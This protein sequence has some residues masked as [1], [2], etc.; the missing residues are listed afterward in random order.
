MLTEAPTGAGVEAAQRPRSWAARIPADLWILAG[1]TVLA[2]VLRFATLTTQSYWFDE[3]QAAH[4][5][6]LGFGAMLSTWNAN[7]PNPPLFFVLAWPWAHIFG[8]GEAGLRS[9]SAI[10]GVAVIPI[11]WLCG[12][13]LV[14]SRAGLVAAAL[15]AVNPFLIWYSQEAR[16]YMLLTALTG[17]S[18]WLL[19]RAWRAPTAGRL[20]WWA[21]VAALA[22]STQYFA[23]FL[24]GPEA[25]VLLYMLRNRASVVAV[26]PPVAAGL[27]FLPHALDHA[28]HPAG[29]INSVGP[30]AVRLKQV[31]VAFGLNTLYRSSIV[32]YGL[33]G[34]ALLVGVLIVL[35][36]AGAEGRQLRGAGIAAGLAACALLIPLTLALA[37]HDY[38]EA[39]ALIPAW[40]PL[41]VVIGAAAT[42]ARARAPGAVLVVVLL[43][44][45]VWAGIRISDHPQYQR[46]DWQGVAAAL[47]KA[48]RTRAIIAYDGPFAAA[49]LAVLLRGVDWTGSG[50]NPQPGNAT[51]H[52]KEVDVIGNTAQRVI[53]P[54]PAG[55]RLIGSKQVAGYL[56]AR[57]RIRGGW[58]LPRASIGARAPALLGPAAPGP[59]VL[60]QRP[61]S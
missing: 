23:V 8:T 61:I 55:V 51:L 22:L 17:A 46:P 48:K 19:V 49:P 5:L 31:P 26:A 15:A 34:A 50:Q 20:A 44:G 12:R 16:E 35:L 30:L 33:L 18:V 13:E 52:V 28:S 53:R 25:L 1:L 27:A 56:V 57:F 58:R 11:V 6:H 9:L 37:G 2:A 60:V 10:A 42:A 40:I 21:V 47:G 24:I 4:E 32:D 14:S 36:V 43:A 7:E 59:A 41:A 45:F 38:Y 54:L 3:A 39:R 29:W